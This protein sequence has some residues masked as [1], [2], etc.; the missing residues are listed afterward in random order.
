MAYIENLKSFL[1]AKNKIIST[2][3]IAYIRNPQIS[4]H[5]NPVI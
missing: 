5:W 1:T 4:N 2:V 3:R